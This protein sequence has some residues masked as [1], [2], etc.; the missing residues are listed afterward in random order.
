MTPLSATDQLYQSQIYLFVSRIALHKYKCN[1]TKHPKIVIQRFQCLNGNTGG[2]RHFASCVER[3]EF[4]LQMDLW[5]VDILFQNAEPLEIG[6]FCK[7]L[8]LAKSIQFQI[9]G[10]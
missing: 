6:T 5:N 10:Y 7:I 2:S 8:I 4:K 3:F 9:Y 1:T